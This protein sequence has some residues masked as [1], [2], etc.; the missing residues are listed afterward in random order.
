MNAK[1]EDKFTPPYISFR[2]LLNLVERLEQGIPPRIDRSFL[3]GSEGGKT[4]VLAALRSLGL[5]GPDGEVQPG[6]VELVNDRDGRAAW[7]KDLIEHLYPKPVQLGTMN[8]TQR[9]L[10]EAFEEFGIRG[11]TLR[12]A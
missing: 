8:A 1:A 12:K 3:S 4:Q 7:I 10:E 2:T 11:D 6:L 9:Q 5:I